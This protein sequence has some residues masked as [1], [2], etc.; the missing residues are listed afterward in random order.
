M[1]KTT[2]LSGSCEQCDTCYIP[3]INKSCIRE[4]VFWKCIV[5]PLL[6]FR[7][8]SLS[9][10]WNCNDSEDMSSLNYFLW[11]VEPL[12]VVFQIISSNSGCL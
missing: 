6:P 9:C 1:R 3:C 4:D 12:I 11:F 5:P 2:I 10:L 8:A 7:I